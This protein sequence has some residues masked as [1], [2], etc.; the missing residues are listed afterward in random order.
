VNISEFFADPSFWGISLAIVF[1]LVWIVP[2]A[3]RKLNLIPA[4]LV[5]LL[6]A[7]VFA[8]C[9]VW[10]Q[11]PLQDWISDLLIAKMGSEEAMQHLFITSLPIV[12][13]SGIIQEGAKMLPTISFWLFKN[14]KIS[15]KLGLTMG[16]MAGAGFGILEGQWITNMIFASGWT[17]DA[18]RT[19]GFLGFAGFWERFFTIGFHIALGALTGWGLAKGKGWLFYLIAAI[20]HGLTN[21]SVVWVQTGRINVIQIESIIAVIAVLVW[22]FIFWLRWKKTWDMDEDADDDE[23]ITNFYNGDFS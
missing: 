14:R 23:P 5:L 19:A 9:I 12:L 22:G 13:M 8:P 15:P 6:G 11:I 7:A 16:A 2:L 18:A 1:G 4:W 3:P 10:L 20:L 21:Y 17:F